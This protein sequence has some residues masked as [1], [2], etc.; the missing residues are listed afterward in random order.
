MEN[1]PEL[2]ELIID[3]EGQVELTKMSGGG[4]RLS[5][6]QQDSITEELQPSDVKRIMKWLVA[7]FV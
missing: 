7:N 6:F 2:I 5:I 1:E 3:T 4:L